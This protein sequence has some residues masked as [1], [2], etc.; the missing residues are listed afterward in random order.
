ML[1]DLS[2]RGSTKQ[3]LSGWRREWLFRAC[4]FISE[5]MPRTVCP[6]SRQDDLIQCEELIQSVNPPF[7]SFPSEG[8]HF[9]TSTLLRTE[10]R[11]PTG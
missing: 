3:K 2:P 7:A 10:L 8:L 4:G 11:R 5:Q 6:G 9:V 1:I